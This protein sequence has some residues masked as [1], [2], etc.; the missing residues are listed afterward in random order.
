LV[1]ASKGERDRFFAALQAHEQGHIELVAQELAHVDEELVGK[2]VEG[3]ARAWQSA[4]DALLL[5]SHAYDD[6]TD[7]G[8]NQGAIIDVSVGSTAIIPFDE[9]GRRL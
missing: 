3:A 5:A 8:R 2:S 7:H 1:T 4:L 6:Q 9:T